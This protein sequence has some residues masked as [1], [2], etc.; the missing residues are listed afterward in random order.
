M[1]NVSRAQQ[2]R[3]KNLVKKAN[4][5]DN[6]KANGPFIPQATKRDKVLRYRREKL[7]AIRHRRPL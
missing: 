2:V 4:V 3:Q 5:H 6:N 1:T 7:K